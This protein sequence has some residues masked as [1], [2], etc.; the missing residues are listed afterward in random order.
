MDDSGA[1][2]ANDP[3]LGLVPIDSS[4]WR[5]AMGVRVDDAQLRF[6]ADHQ[7]IAL[8]VLAK[9]YVRPGGLIW[10]PFV[11]THERSIIGLVTLAHTPEPTEC[12]LMHFV[13]D[14]GWQR[15]GLGRAS[16]AMIIEYV[17]IMYPS[18]TSLVLTVDPEN[19]VGLHLYSR[20]GFQPTGL[21]RMG[22]PVLRLDLG[23]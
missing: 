22:E 14:H 12:E 16:F 13:I 5:M 18:L 11:I 1:H 20:L 15:R 21:E 3:Q 4:N 9:A 2:S 10:E 8:V 7:P 23:R 17:Q 19:E 6:V